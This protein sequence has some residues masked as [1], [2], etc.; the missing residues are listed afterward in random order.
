[1]IRPEHVRLIAE[2]EIGN[3][4]AEPLSGVV[5]DAVYLGA[6]VR[7]EIELDSGTVVTVRRPPHQ[8]PSIGAGDRVG[9]TWD[10]GHAVHLR[11]DGDAD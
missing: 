5:S 3:A 10:P 6:S 7:I 11:N 9:V 1:M 4:P 8:S 2:S